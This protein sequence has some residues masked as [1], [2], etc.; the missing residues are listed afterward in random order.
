MRAD[1]S[2]HIIAAA[3]RRAEQTRLRAITTLRRMDSTG[4]QIDFKTVAR[5]AGVSRS[6]LYTQQDLRAQIDRLR[7]RH[8]QR[9]P[10]VV[11]DR[12]RASD[13][14]LLR[15]LQIATDRIHRLEEENREIREALAQALGQRRTAGILG[16]T[17]HG[18][19]PKRNPAKIIGPC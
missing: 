3:R 13:V 6:W 14:S 17:D 18:D 16:R 15:R 12:Q 10:T 2:R 19:T 7:S 1:N 4:A 11:P 8:P 5:E 9:S